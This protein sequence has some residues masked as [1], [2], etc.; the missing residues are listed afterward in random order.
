[1]A[2]NEQQRTSQVLERNV[3]V[4][5]EWWLKSKVDGALDT[6]GPCCGDCKREALRGLGVNIEAPRKTIRVRYE[7]VDSRVQVWSAN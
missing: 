4:K 7:C 6:G 5:M 2:F 3:S 1:M